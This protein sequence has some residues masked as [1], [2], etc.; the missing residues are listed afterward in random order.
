MEGVYGYGREIGDERLFYCRGG[1]VLRGDTNNLRCLESGKWSD[2]LP[3]CEAVV[4]HVSSCA[5][6]S[7]ESWQRCEATG[8][9]TTVC[10]CINP[11]S[12]LTSGPTVC[13]TN[14]DYYRS[15]C[16]L[17]AHACLQDLQLDIAENDHG[18]INGVPDEGLAIQPT[19]DDSPVVF[20]SFSSF[21]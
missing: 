14:G 10:G 19:A 15:E 12:C 21:D 1:Y 8:P 4:H 17:K 11:A 9:N 20:S 13:G 7:C 2:P 6:V 16:H 3:T 18:C 5:N